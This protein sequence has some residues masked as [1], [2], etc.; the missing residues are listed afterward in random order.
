MKRG[1]FLVLMLGA[2]AGVLGLRRDS[3]V[4]SF[5]HRAHVYA[6]IQCQDCHSEVA[7]DGD[8][9]PVA[10][11]DEQDCRGCHVE[12][13]DQRPCMTCHASPVAAG[14]AVEARDHLSFSHASHVPRLDGDCVRCHSGV[15]DETAGAVLRP[16]MATCLACHAHQDQ[17]DPEAC[18]T[19]HVDLETEDVL[20][21]SHVVHDGDWLVEHGTRAAGAG[22]FCATCHTESSCASCHGVTTAALPSRMAF[23]DPDGSIHRSGFASRHSDE[24]RAAPGTCT[25][26]H[27]ESSCKTCHDRE[28]LTASGL[29]PHG[30]GWVGI[31][32]AENEHGRAARLDPAECAS[33]HSGDGEQ[34]CVSC[35]AVG[36]VGG[37]PHPVGWSSEQPLEGRPC[38]QCH[39]P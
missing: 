25:S 24:A 21:S 23:D 17:F 12:P 13:H 20:P 35:H 14:A 29:S 31:T 9:S 6:N 10:L 27:E 37:N 4:E 11:P 22:D 28:G 16:K 7:Q 1:L 18:D 39:V 2:C 19:C 5:P 34:L 33:C 32:S 38:R 3:A 36:G 30:P 15:R 8:T 26:C